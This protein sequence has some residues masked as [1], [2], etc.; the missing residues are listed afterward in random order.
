MRT[1]PHHHPVF[2]SAVAMSPRGISLV[3]NADL[4]LKAV[5]V[6]VAP[7]ASPGRAIANRTDPRPCRLATLRN[8]AYETVRGEPGG[9][10]CF[11]RV[12]C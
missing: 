2:N 3:W 4:T 11:E 9:F 1:V 7:V 10:V 5:A 6:T 12:I 8:S